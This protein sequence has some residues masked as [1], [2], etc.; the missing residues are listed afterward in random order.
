MM[1]IINSYLPSTIFHIKILMIILMMMMMSTTIFTFNLPP[2]LI[3]FSRIVY[4][5]FHIKLVVLSV[6]C[7]LAVMMVMIL[8]M[9]FII[10]IYVGTSLQWLVSIILFFYSYLPMQSFLGLCGRVFPTWSFDQSFSYCEMN[11]LVA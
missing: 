1:M 6:I 9:I 4:F 8:M 5:N 10:V 7:L 3:L 11:K 2:N